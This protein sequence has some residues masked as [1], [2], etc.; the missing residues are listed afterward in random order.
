MTH[1]KLTQFQQQR[2]LVA[3]ACGMFDYSKFK[4]VDQ[5]VFLRMQP[6]QTQHDRTVTTHCRK[7][8]IFGTIP[9]I[10]R[11]TIRVHVYNSFW[12]AQ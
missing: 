12:C 7:E 8:Y 6:M 9:F 4:Y 11:Q 2:D 1:F 5:E 3:R 10:A